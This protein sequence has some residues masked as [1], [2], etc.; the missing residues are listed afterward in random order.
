MRESHPVNLLIKH[1]QLVDDIP[2]VKKVVPDTERKA[3]SC[4]HRFLSLVPMDDMLDFFQEIN[5][6]YTF[7]RLGPRSHRMEIWYEGGLKYVGSG[8][9]PKG[10]M[11]EAVARF[12]TKETKDYHDIGQ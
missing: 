6:R 12:F 8:D 11:A 5:I 2:Q 3:V 7:Q 1:R 9:S 10:A 4:L